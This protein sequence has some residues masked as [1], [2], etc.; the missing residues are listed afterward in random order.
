MFIFFKKEQGDS[1]VLGGCVCMNKDVL[2]I[3]PE[4]TDGSMSRFLEPHFSAQAA[5]KNGPFKSNSFF[6]ETNWSTE[7]SQ[8]LPSAKCMFARCNAVMMFF[9]VLTVW[10]CLLSLHL[11]SW[12]FSVLSVFLSVYTRRLTRSLIVRRSLTSS[13]FNLKPLLRH[14]FRHS[15]FLK[16]CPVLQ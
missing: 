13:L 15:V 6:Q 5:T 14:V 3:L 8:S 2:C 4:N 16:M 11:N 7:S 9:C 10:V 12:Y 1:S